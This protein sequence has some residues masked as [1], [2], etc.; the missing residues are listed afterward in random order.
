MTLKWTAML[1]ASALLA[2]GCSDNSS[3]PTAGPETTDR[4]TVAIPLDVGPV[5]IFVE[6]E[7]WISELVYDKLVAPSPFV[8]DPQPWLASEVTMVDPSTWDVTVRDDVTW[9]DGEPFTAADVE[10]TFAYA[11]EADTGRWTHHVTTIPEITSTTQIDANTVR[12]ECAFACP[13][14]GTVTLADLPILPEHIWSQIPPESVKEVTALPVGTGPYRLAEY[15]PITGYRFTAFDEYFGGTP[16]V[17][18]LVMQVI[19]DPSATFTALRAGEIDVASRQVP[20]ELLDVFEASD[21]IEVVNTTPL[22][23]VDLRMNYTR[24]MFTDPLVRSAISL[25]LDKEELLDVVML[26][27][28]R[29]ATQ[30]RMHPDSPW[31]DPQASA[32]TDPERARAILDDAGYR[33][34]NGDGLRESPDGT[35]IALTLEVNGAEPTQVRAAE[36]V[37][38]QL[39]A[40]GLTVTVTPQDAGRHAT[41]S[42]RMETFDLLVR[43]GVPHTVADPTQYV[44]SLFSGSSWNLEDFPYPELQELVDNWKQTATLEDRREAGFEIQRFLNE[45]PPVVALYHPDKY[46]AYRAGSYGGFVDSPGY[47]IM[48]K[49]S[50]IPLDR[51]E[52]ANAVVTR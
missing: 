25:A 48:H 43:D 27:R 14:L 6:H 23:Q 49:W 31:A 37:A 15:D 42:N 38:E 17:N 44:L 20:P 13:E 5:N 52:A 16:R 22:E 2:A 9:H 26:G 39:G 21:T 12:F 50:L 32:P 19:E 3:T 47:G 10:F 7:E 33:D 36:V 28:G 1:C 40:V 51:A 8:D 18:E 4:L 30:G 34:T 24:P 41:S 35:P 29:P 11:Q 46:F 45:V